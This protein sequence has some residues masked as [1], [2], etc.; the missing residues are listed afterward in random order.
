M[1]KFRHNLSGRRDSSVVDMLTIRD[2]LDLCDFDEEE[3]AAIAEHEHIPEIVAIELAEYLIH[4]EEGVPRIRRI[5]LDDIRD[6]ASRG[7]AVRAEHLT[8]VLKH[9][10][11]THP[12]YP[13]ARRET[14]ARESGG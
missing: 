12:E 9:F 4:T 5:I 11:A 1:G 8:L 6:A 2:C 7:D 3:I 13:A 14:K 10:I